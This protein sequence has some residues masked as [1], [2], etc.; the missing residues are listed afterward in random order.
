LFGEKY[1]LSFRVWRGDAAAVRPSFSGD[2]GKCSEPEY[3]F[4]HV[5]RRLALTVLVVAALAPALRGDAA[6]PVLIAPGVTLAGVPVGGMSNEQA[7]AALRPAFATPVRLVYGD[8]RWKLQPTRFGA[9]VTI[10]DGVLQALG[11]QAGAAVPLVPQVNQ[12]E[13]RRFVQALDK[14]VS[15]A[16]QDAELKGLKGLRPQ[17][18]KEQP[19]IKVLRELT[20][21]R[22]V[23]ALQ[24]P[25]LR[26][27]RVA[28][29]VL[30]P[31]RT[32]VNFGPVIVI[33]RGA[34]EL[35]YYKGAQLLRKFGVATGQAVYPTPTGTF[36]IVDLQLNPWWLPP[37]SAW[38]KGKKPIPPGPGNPLGTRWMGLSAPGVGIHGTPDDA[39][40]GYS[41]SHG[42]IRMHIP[43]AEWLFHHV[44]LGT[45]V[46]ITE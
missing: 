18:T 6:P 2:L 26:R 13:V 30:V 43:D 17:F 4:V 3:D 38:A 28:V 27:I 15:T 45:P 34:N 39:S 1:P 40:I 19:G 36:K 11:A 44:K 37:D 14:R 5:I 22:I 29:K 35:R 10:A 25:Q 46:V 42:C 32:V 20:I 7:E 21:R 33:R 12:Q 9:R 8:R 31:A 23:R 16:P 24:S 41:A